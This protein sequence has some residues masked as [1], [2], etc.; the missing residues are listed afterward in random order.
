MKKVRL[1]ENI[2]K[3]CFQDDA[4]ELIETLTQ[5]ARVTNEELLKQSKSTTRAIEEINEAN[6]YVKS[7]EFLNRK[8]QLIKI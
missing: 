8:E 2:S 3:K 1:R 4:R 7:L 5:A 6:V